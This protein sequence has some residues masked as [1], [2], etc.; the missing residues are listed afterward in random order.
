MLLYLKL[1]AV[2][3]QKQLLHMEID[4]R[5][6]ELQDLQD[7]L[8]ASQKAIEKANQTK[9]ELAKKLTASLKLFRIQ[10]RQK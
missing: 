3:T 10:I 8:E 6:Q 5:N 1:K 9:S 4:Q 7:K 2:E